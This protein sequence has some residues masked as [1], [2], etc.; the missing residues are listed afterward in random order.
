[1]AF[2]EQSAALAGVVFSM[3]SPV[4]A[5]VATATTAVIA[6]RCFFE[7]LYKLLKKVFLDITPN[8]LDGYV[9]Q[10]AHFLSYYINIQR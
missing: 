5:P 10:T 3:T 9:L 6:K 7:F 1:M 2:A 8:L 4:K